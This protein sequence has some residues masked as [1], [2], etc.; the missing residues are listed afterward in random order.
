MFPSNLNI[1]GSSDRVILILAPCRSG[2][3]A[4]LNAFANGGWLSL[5]QPI[6]AAVRRAHA[7]EIEPVIINMPKNGIV[8]KETFG[9]YFKAEVDYNPVRVLI[10]SGVNPSSLQVI[11]LFR[12]PEECLT[13]WIKIFRPSDIDLSLFSESYQKVRDN[14]VDAHNRGIQVVSLPYE[15]LANLRVFQDLLSA[16]DIKFVP[17][18]LDWASSPTHHPGRV[19]FEYI[20]QPKHDDCL[21]D[22]S[23]SRVFSVRS[24]NKIPP[25][26]PQDIAQ[27]AGLATAQAI[28]ES[29]KSISP[30]Y[31]YNKRTVPKN[32]SAPPQP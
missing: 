28:Y 16:L 22:V 17:T 24:P 8:I 7:G 21:E 20:H 12:R 18:M 4:V 27:K 32:R 3:S 29:I 15:A 9:P 10:D 23:N 31:L 13:S 2:S 25:T 14:C 26:I 6:K 1:N 5:Y 11:A 30:D 19:A